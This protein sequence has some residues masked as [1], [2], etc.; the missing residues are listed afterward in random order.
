MTGAHVI[1][2]P[3]LYRLIMRSDKPVA[4][5]RLHIKVGDCPSPQEKRERARGVND[6]YTHGSL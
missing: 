4:R 5:A 2:E 1:S 3:G 6:G